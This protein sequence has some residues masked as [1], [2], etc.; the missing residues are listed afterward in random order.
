VIN[1]ILLLIS[2]CWSQTALESILQHLFMYAFIQHT[3]S[4]VLLYTWVIFKGCHMCA[5]VQW[6]PVPCCHVVLLYYINFCSTLRNTLMT[7][8]TVECLIQT[9]LSLL[10]SL[11]I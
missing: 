1:A 11:F 2:G 4:D 3:L 6:R 9:K 8:I 7:I 5:R 10:C